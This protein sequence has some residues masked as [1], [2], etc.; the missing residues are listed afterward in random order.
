MRHFFA[1]VVTYAIA[2]ILIGGAA[3]FAWARSA[4]VTLTNESTVL[5]QYEQQ[6]PSE[7]P[8]GDLGRRSYERNCGTC[9]LRDGSGWD[10]YPPLENARSLVGASGGREYFV[11]LHLYGLASDRWS[12]PM[13][14]MGHLQDVELA[15]VLNHVVSRFGGSERPDEALLF[16]PADV[17]SRRHQALAPHQVNER[18]PKLQ[19]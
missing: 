2:G 17:R 15:A 11:D 9:H 8:S 4:Q 1:N 3:L 12:A 6:Q 5:A 13:P 19:P 16:R 14:P 10:Q 18:R 7:F